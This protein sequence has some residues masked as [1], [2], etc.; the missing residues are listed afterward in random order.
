MLL[1]L[2]FEISARVAASPSAVMLI[3]GKS[4]AAFTVSEPEYAE[5]PVFSVKHCTRCQL[6][7]EG[8]TRACI[9]A[10]CPSRDR[11]AA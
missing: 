4:V 6:V 9:A 8:P 5:I 11:K 10:D 3:N 7:G 2:P 1:T